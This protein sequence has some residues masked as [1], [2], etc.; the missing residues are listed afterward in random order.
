[1]HD[2]IDVAPP[3]EGHG[4]VPAAETLA[5]RRGSAE[6]AAQVFIAASRCV[7]IPA[8]FVSGYR[9]G[10]DGAGARHGWAEAYSD[11]LGWGGFDPVHCL[12]VTDA[13][14]RVGVGLDYLGAA[15][16][17][18]VNAARCVEKRS[19]AVTVNQAQGQRQS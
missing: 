13:Y 1:V 4:L 17:R 9:I 18:S 10:D 14:V 12:C 6:D 5:L 8:R 2:F 16:L 7:G 15:P 3:A 19:V 11:G